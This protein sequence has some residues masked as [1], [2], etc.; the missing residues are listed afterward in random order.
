MKGNNLMATK[1]IVCKDCGKEFELTDAEQ[2]WF[3]IKGFEFPKR[4]KEC[5][6]SK[7]QQQRN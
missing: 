4:C 1:T 7:K 6:Q 2:E 3:K 5:R